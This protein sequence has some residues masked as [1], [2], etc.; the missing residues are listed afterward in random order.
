[1]KSD[2]SLK[3][4]RNSK[5]I[6]SARSKSSLHTEVVI[7]SESFRPIIIAKKEEGEE[8]ETHQILS[9]IVTPTF[10]PLTLKPR[11]QKII[12]TPQQ[13]PAVNQSLPM[14]DDDDDDSSDEFDEEEWGDPVKVVAV[15][16]S[17]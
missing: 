3:C 6:K 17:L 2:S 16:K 4:G 9:N 7:K 14:D 15:L 13:Q 8:E 12:W 1:M 5:T 11:T 10:V